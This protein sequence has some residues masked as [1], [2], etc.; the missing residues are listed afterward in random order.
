ME[1]EHFLYDLQFQQI[2]SIINNKG[3]NQCSNPKANAAG[4]SS[5]LS[6]APLRLRRLILDSG[7]T[8]HITSSPNL[9]VNSRQNTILPPI[10]MPS[11]EQAPITSTGTLPLN[12]V[13]SLKNVLGVPSFKVDLMSVSQVTRSLNCSVTFF[14]S[15]CI[16]QDLT[17]KTTIGLG[18][19]RDGLYYFWSHW[20]QQHR[21][22][23]SDPPLP[24]LTSI[25][26]SCHLLH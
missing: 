8:D 7:A 18:K 23:N 26:F 15:W 25:L 5:S 13:I 2:L 11:G 21:A 16:L 20:R 3:A 17:T 10:I 24:L 22:L 12:S 14:P 19:Q 1:R 4:T 6:Q 9:L